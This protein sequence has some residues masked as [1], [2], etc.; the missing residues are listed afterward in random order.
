MAPPPGRPATG[1]ALGKVENDAENDGEVNAARGPLLAAAA[2]AVAV[3]VA[4]AGGGG[5]DSG[6]LNDDDGGGGGGG[7]DTRKCL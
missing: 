3:A 1:L 4:A 2:V 6:G 5:P 7:G